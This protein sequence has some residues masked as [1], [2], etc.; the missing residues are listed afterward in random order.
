MDRK[1]TETGP[2]RNRLQPDRWLRLPAFQNEKTAKRP[3]AMDRLQSVAT[4]FRY[5]LKIHTF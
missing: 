1:K 2:D 3:V 4:G 5:A